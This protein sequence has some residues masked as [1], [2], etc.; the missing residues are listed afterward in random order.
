MSGYKPDDLV[1]EMVADIYEDHEIREYGFDPIQLCKEMGHLVLPYSSF[2]EDLKENRP[3]LLMKLDKDGFSWFNPK[4]KKC[5]IYYNNNRS[6]RLRYKFTIPHELGH[7]EFGHVFEEKITADMEY[8]A[9]EF[10]RQLYV[11]HIILVKKK[12]LTLH[13]VMSAFDI[14]ITYADIVLER[15]DNRLKYQGDEF[16][17][18]EYRIL[19]AFDYNRNRNRLFWVIKNAGIIGVIPARHVVWTTSNIVI[20]AW[21]DLNSPSFWW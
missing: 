2:S 5:E 10:A 18:Q 4:T 8:V 21:R 11:P 16:S 14:T 1:L 7:I 17:E 9:N 3:D 15:L 6:P 13:E 19:K 12:I 20:L